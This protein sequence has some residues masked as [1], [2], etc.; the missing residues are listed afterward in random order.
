M[1]VRGAFSHLLPATFPPPPLRHA[2]SLPNLF[3]PTASSPLHAAACELRAPPMASPVLIAE[4]HCTMLI[5]LPPL[6]VRHRPPHCIGP[7]AA[8]QIHGHGDRCGVRCG[9][10]MGSPSYGCVYPQVDESYL[11]GLAAGYRYMRYRMHAFWGILLP[12][13][14]SALCP[15]YTLSPSPS[16][17]DVP[18]ME[19]LR[20]YTFPTEES[21]KDRD[22]AEVSLMA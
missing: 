9:I 17:A 16:P 12:P 5:A 8:I 1:C 6:P 15:L 18:L 7:C 4:L 3:L 21:Y 14:P 13:L 22:A 19:W 2:V 10:W 20:K 11:Q